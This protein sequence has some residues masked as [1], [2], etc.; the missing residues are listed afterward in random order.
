MWRPTEKDYLEFSHYNGK[1]VMDHYQDW[2]TDGIGL[3]SAN[4]SQNI[5]QSLKWN[6]R[7]G[8]NWSTDIA[9]VKTSYDYDMLNVFDKNQLLASSS[10]SDY[11]T[12]MSVRKDYSGR[13]F[14]KAGVDYTY[15]NVSPN[16]INT[17]GVVSQ[18][19]SGG[20]IEGKDVHESG[21][22]SQ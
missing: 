17:S 11:G 20:E 6:H 12:Q 13:A 8:D 22:Y 2:D 15:H 19:V 1:D 16:L 7:V 3:T 5:S 14:F 10:I 9:L 4:S 21:I 18:F